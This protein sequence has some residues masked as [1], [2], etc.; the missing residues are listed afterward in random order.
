MKYNAYSYHLVSLP[1]LRLSHLRFYLPM[2]WHHQGKCQHSEK[3]RYHLVLWVSRY[4]N[5][6]SRPS[7]GFCILLSRTRF[8]HFIPHSPYLL[9][10]NKPP[11]KLWLVCWLGP[12]SKARASLDRMEHPY[13]SSLTAPCPSRVLQTAS[14]ARCTPAPGGLSP[15]GSQCSDQVPAANSAQ[16]T[17]KP[18]PMAMLRTP[19]LPGAHTA[20]SQLR[21]STDCKDNWQWLSVF[22]NPRTLGGLNSAL[23]ELAIYSYFETNGSLPLTRTFQDVLHQEWRTFMHS[24]L[25]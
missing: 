23:K 19:A 15:L 2:P 14:A 21:I 24:L 1:W 11:K 8:Y 6:N 7:K 17:Q 9:P 22:L 5:E 25:Q 4:Y 12:P 10:G 13:P 3:G 20:R 18:V 16:L